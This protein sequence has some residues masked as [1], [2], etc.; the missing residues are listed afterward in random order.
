MVVA[1]TSALRL[2]SDALGWIGKS[3]C[4]GESVGAPEV[5][6]DLTR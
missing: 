5:V 4:D 2:W 3:F 1:S 6:D